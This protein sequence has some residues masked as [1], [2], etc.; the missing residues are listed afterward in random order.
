MQ[1]FLNFLSSKQNVQIFLG[2]IYN[3]GKIYL[4]LP[5][6]LGLEHVYLVSI[7]RC[8]LVY[9]PCL[10]HA[11]QHAKFSVGSKTDTSECLVSYSLECHKSVFKQLYV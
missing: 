1:K 5:V 10:V 8:P 11:G 7:G 2:F 4:V 3:Q 6:I 9:G